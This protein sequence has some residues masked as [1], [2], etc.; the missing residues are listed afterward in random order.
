MPKC[1]SPKRGNIILTEE[2]EEERL[3]M[4]M[5]GIGLLAIGNVCLGFS[6][7]SLQNSFLKS[8]NSSPIDTTRGDKAVDS[9]NFDFL[10]YTQKGVKN[11]SSSYQL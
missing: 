7:S 10:E 11:R 2:K 8:G 9:K 5:F 6:S 3:N 1:R 4:D